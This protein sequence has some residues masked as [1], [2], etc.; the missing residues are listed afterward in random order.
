MLDRTPIFLSIK[1]KTIGV[2]VVRVA[3]AYML[4]SII[5]GSVK[6]GVLP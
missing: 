2:K 5:W 6:R 4:A 3:I 1:N